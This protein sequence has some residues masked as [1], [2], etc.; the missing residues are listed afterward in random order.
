MGADFSSIESRVLARAA[1][2]EWK[3]QNYRD[4]DATGRPELEPYRATASR[5]LSMAP[6]QSR[7]HPL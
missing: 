7:R 1:D 4:Y 6:F 3:L 5:M 2:E